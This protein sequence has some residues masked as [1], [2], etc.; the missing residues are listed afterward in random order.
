MY[1]KEDWE[2][3][4][5]RLTA[6]WDREI[7]DRCCISVAAPR[8]GK[9]NVHIFAQGECNPDDPADVEDYWMN[10]ERIWKRNIQR[11]ENAYFGGESLPVVMPN[12]GTSGHCVYYGARYILRPET[13]WFEP[14]VEDLDGYPWKYDRE[15]PFYRRQ[16]E[17]VRYLA[18]KGKGNYLLSMPDNCGT[19]DAIGH[20]H[21][22]SETLLDM[23]DEPEALSE[24]IVAINN[25]WTDAAET[26]YQLMKDCNE[27]GGCVGWMDTWAPGR[28]AQMQCD[29]SVMFSPDCYERFAVPELKKQMEWVEYPVYHLDGKEQI[30]HLDHLLALDQLKMIQWMNVEGQET[31]AHFIPVLKRMQEAGKVVLVMTPASDIPALMENL[32][33]KGLYL[34]TYASSVDEANFII[35]YVE[36]HTHE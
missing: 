6:L 35:R 11:L 1:Y 34:H 3:A 28:H 21:G 20:L 27:G 29:M 9:T 30:N 15:N 13:I 5:K 23:Y 12:F 2:Q 24:A 4:K 18:E 19:L 31:P 14:V 8:D 25:G 33:S 7:L 26:F 32:S 10:P 36:Q 22:S 16:R 17:I